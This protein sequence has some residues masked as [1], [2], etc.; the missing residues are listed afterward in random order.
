MN[1]LNVRNIIQVHNNVMWDWQYSRP[2]TTTKITIDNYIFFQYIFY[3]S[4]N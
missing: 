4:C 2:L 3:N 1:F